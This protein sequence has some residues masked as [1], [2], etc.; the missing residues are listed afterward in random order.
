MN[1]HVLY[2]DSFILVLSNTFLLGSLFSK[3]LEYWQ[4]EGHYPAGNVVICSDVMPSVATICRVSFV[5]KIWRLPNDAC[6][7]YA[8]ILELALNFQY[9]FYV[10]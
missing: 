10:M 2:Y 7:P 8:L 4:A 6:V 9:Y 1:Y 5:P 3:P